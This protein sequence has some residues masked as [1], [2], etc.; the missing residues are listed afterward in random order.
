VIGFETRRFVDW[1]DCDAAGIVFYPNF[2]RWMD[3]HFHRFT[4][5]LGFDQRRLIDEFGLLG[6][7]L[8]K[9]SCTFHAA[10]SFG[11][12]LSITSRLTAIGDS[13]IGVAYR[14]D[15]AETAIAEGS[16]VRVVVRRGAQGIAKASIPG[17]VREALAVHLGPPGQTLD[18]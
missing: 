11:D 15:R 6:T 3:G 7:P 5:T 14:F 18:R 9:A 8:R 2:Y 16:E 4:A 17:P 13:S 10:A 1:G 12:T